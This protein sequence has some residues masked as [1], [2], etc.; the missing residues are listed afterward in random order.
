[1]RSWKLVASVIV[2]AVVLVVTELAYAESVALEPTAI[3]PTSIASIVFVSGAISQDTT[4]TADNLYVMQ[5]DVSIDPGTRLRIEPGVIIKGQANVRLLVKGVLDAQGTLDRPIVF[6]SFKDDTYGGD[7]NGDG[8]ASSPAPN[9][10]GWIEY[11]DSSADAVNVLSYVVVKYGGRSR[12]CDSWSCWNY[13]RGAVDLGDASPTIAHCTI[14]QFGGYAISMDTNSF[15]IVIG[16][17]LTGNGINGIGVYGGTINTG[18]DTGQWT[19]QDA[20]YVL[21]GDIRIAEGKRLKIQ[22]GVIIKG[23][24][25]VRFF[26]DGILDAQGILDRPVVFTSLKDDAYGGDTNGD[27]NA[28]SPAPNDWGWI[29][30]TDSS[31]DA[32]N[33]LS[34]A[35]IKYAGQGAIATSSASPTIKYATLTR[36]SGGI[37][38]SGASFPIITTNS[39]YR[40]S[41]YGLGYAGTAVVL[42][43]TNWWGH[44]SGPY[45]PSNNSSD[46]THL[47]NPLGRG[48]RVSD[49]VDYEPW[50]R[51]PMA[52]PSLAV[53]D[54]V[55]FSDSGVRPK[56]TVMIGTP[57]QLAVP[58]ECEFEAAHAEFAGGSFPL[59]DAD[60]DTLW[61]GIISSDANA[62]TTQ[63]VT[64]TVS[65]DTCAFDSIPVAEVALIAPIGQVHDSETSAAIGGA[66]VTL[67]RY[68]TSQGLYVMWDGYPFGQVNPQLTDLNGHFAWQPPAGRYYVR[69]RKE[70][71]LESQTSPVDVSA[72][73]E[74]NISLIR[75]V[76]LS[77][78]LM[79]DSSPCRVD[80]GCN[81]V[82]RVNP[83]SATV[84]ITYWWESAGQSSLTQVNGITS[85]HTFTW[86]T[87]GSKNVLVTAQNLVGAITATHSI[88]VYMPISDLSIESPSL[89]QVNQNCSFTARV[90]PMT[91]TPPMMYLWQSADQPDFQESNGI[92]SVHALKWTSP[93]TKR[94]TVTV[95]NTVSQVATSASVTVR[96]AIYLPLLL[97]DANR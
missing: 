82:A 93:G 50:S 12:A 10:W 52:S 39:I 7:T 61:T 11:T 41:S 42:A 96:A 78:V 80:V 20:V 58:L 51:L 15:P 89:C 62:G 26:V 53:S 1:M 79:E 31:A 2:S 86:T 24:T 59:T 16:N 17:V 40:N 68:D 38:L 3:G 70:G 47:Y 6:T 34:H 29:E 66:E 25:N 4:W 84:P 44:Y 32:V 63:L 67:Y 85:T 35:V 45:D 28:S 54:T 36:N 71:Y 57:I 97:S 81:F 88:T 87:P 46:P 27:G 75:L 23:Q 37:R 30:Y 73:R 74:L 55:F 60:A 90:N 48:D 64:V 91:A 14:M 72:L 19:S 94:V 76:S 18:G 65:S 95:R 33:V 22:P 5:G 43:E 49:Y 8:N 83:I 77:N 92:S 56:I 9:D 21:D 69:V 13:S